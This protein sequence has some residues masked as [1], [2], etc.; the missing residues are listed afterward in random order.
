M[1]M[2]SG[3]QSESGPLAIAFAAEIRAAM[4]RHRFSGNQ[5]AAATGMSQNYMAKRLRDEAPFTLNDIEKICDALGESFLDLV[6]AANSHLKQG[7]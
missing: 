7:K 1:T 4:G 6:A 5:L 3:K 2:P